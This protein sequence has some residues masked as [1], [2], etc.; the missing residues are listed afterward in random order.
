MATRYRNATILPQRGTVDVP[1]LRRYRRVIRIL[2]EGCG[3]PTIAHSGGDEGHI[4]GEAEE[5]SGKGGVERRYTGTE[6][7]GGLVRKSDNCQAGRTRSPG[8]GSIGQDRGG[9]VDGPW[10]LA[11]NVVEK[12]HKTRTSQPNITENL[13]SI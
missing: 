3:R 7:S 6:G 5:E 11:G 9:R 13:V 4:A 8:A 2:A 10:S 12:G 1:G